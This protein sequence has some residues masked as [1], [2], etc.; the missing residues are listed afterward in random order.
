MK[1][2]MNESVSK[3]ITLGILGTMREIFSLCHI[4]TKALFVYLWNIAAEFDPPLPCPC[5]FSQ[6]PQS[7]HHW[8][9]SFH[10]ATGS[11]PK[12]CPVGFTMKPPLQ[13]GDLEAQAKF[14]NNCTASTL[15]T[16]PESYH[17]Y[18]RVS[19]PP[20]LAGARPCTPTLFIIIPG[21]PINWASIGW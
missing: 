3:H 16:L 20:S 1:R 18:V 13:T 2:W 5:L 11:D 14:L 12:A 17:F 9:D 4:Y 21:F 15:L 6:V 7:Q 10:P 8:Q 19:S